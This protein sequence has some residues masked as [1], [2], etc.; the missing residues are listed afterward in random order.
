M[1]LGYCRLGGLTLFFFFLTWL[2]EIWKVLQYQPFISILRAGCC[3]CPIRGGDPVSAKLSD[4]WII[5]AGEQ[6]SMENSCGISPSCNVILAPMGM[7]Y[8]YCGWCSLVQSDVAW[9]VTVFD[10][11]AGP[12]AW[13]RLL[14]WQACNFIN[15]SVQLACSFFNLCYMPNQISLISTGATMFDPTKT[16]GYIPI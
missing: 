6:L 1:L 12:S 9:S 13:G 5:Y 10:F 14:C 7:G 8:E 3:P 15:V 2:K 4:G 11:S 16:F